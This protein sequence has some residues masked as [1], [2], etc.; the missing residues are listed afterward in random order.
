MLG[1]VDRY[2][3]RGVSVALAGLIGQGR[4]YRNGNLEVRALVWVDKPDSAL[5]SFYCLA[6][7]RALGSAA[8][9]IYRRRV[10]WSGLVSIVASAGVAGRCTSQADD[11]KTPVVRYSWYYSAQMSKT[12]SAESGPMATHHHPFLTFETKSRNR[13]DQSVQHV[14]KTFRHARLTG[15]PFERRGG[16]GP[17]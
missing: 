17:M 13:K 5:G 16:G 2:D 15:S 6:P 12:W 11:A 7:S 9:L 14:T 4:A 1:C 3:R 8:A 10:E